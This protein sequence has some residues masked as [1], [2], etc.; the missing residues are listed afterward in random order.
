MP[1]AS[2]SP[3]TSV[4]HSGLLTALSLAT[5]TGLAAVVGL[6]IARNFGRGAET[7]G[8]FAAYGI[9]IVIMLAATAFRLVVLPPLARA[10]VEQR[11][12]A[13]TAAYA[14]ALAVLALPAIA[15]STFGSEWAGAQ[16]TGDLPEAARRT[17][18]DVLVWMVPAAMAHLYAGLAS[19]A[20]AA[21]DD[22][23]TSALGYALGS[24]AGL[25]L[26]LLRIDAD[27]I[28]AIAHGMALNGAVSLAVPAAALVLQRGSGAVR[29]RQAGLARR[30]R[31]FARGVALPLAL[32]GLY[33]VCIRFAAELG[34]GAVTS[35]SFAYLIAAA[36]VAITAS[37]LGLVSSVPLTRSGLDGARAAQH[38][39]S[40]AWLALA[41]AAGAAGV[42]ALAGEDI[43]STVLGSAYAGATGSELG[44]L[45]VYLTPWIVA[46]TGVSI[47]F[48]LLFVVDRTRRLP[49]L[50]AGALALHVALAWAGLELLGLPGI[51][52][53]LAASTVVVLAGL[54]A[55]LSRDAVARVAGGLASAAL[56]SGGLAAA[57]YAV[58]ALV[59]AP[60]PAAALG[61]GLYVVLLAA[62]R[63]RGL[64]DAW[65]Y[66]RA[67]H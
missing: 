37:S 6:L 34:E 66:V 33:L 12:A 11:L 26:I 22:Y 8:F 64:R 45:V 19:S 62:L 48:P 24:V 39:V 32:Q 56:V 59:L 4:A 55:L 44:R 65:G 25:A 54:L 10:R 63:P 53:A 60:V 3:R 1:K 13:E 49:L 31:E 15:L 18:G 14:L 28:V 58:L 16:L 46:S 47:T 52:A 61:F 38:V 30:L 35:L 67:L 17:A 20:L 51:V 29:L 23:A 2:A 7:D 57:S 42:F 36:L 43:V 9:F 5:M 50:G 40:T 27:G 21:R 41:V